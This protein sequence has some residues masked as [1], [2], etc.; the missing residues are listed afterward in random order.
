MVAATC[1]IDLLG[2]DDIVRFLEVYRERRLSS[3][4]YLE[5]PLG[6]GMRVMT[7]G[8]ALRLHRG[9]SG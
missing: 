3:R 6:S 7:A 8:T 5:E 4:P 1:I 2:T 9:A